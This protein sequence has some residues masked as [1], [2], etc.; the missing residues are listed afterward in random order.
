M[1]N[2]L[3]FQKNQ[4]KTNKK[5]KKPEKANKFECSYFQRC[6]FDAISIVNIPSNLDRDTTHRYSEN[7]FKL[8]R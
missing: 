5:I 1:I 7:S 6:P 4:K 2:V 8:H 3:K